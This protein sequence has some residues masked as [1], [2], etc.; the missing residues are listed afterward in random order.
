MRVAQLMGV[1]YVT[2]YRFC[3]S[4]LS[5]MGPGKTA[6]TISATDMSN[7]YFSSKEMPFCGQISYIRL[8]IKLIL[9]VETPPKHAGRIGHRKNTHRVAYFP[10][11][12]P[13]CTFWGLEL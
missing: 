3:D 11:F 5:S 12:T 8:V 1:N 13:G 9:W 7:D 2:I 6:W 10:G 4:V